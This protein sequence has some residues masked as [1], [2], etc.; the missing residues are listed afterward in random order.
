MQLMRQHVGNPTAGT[1]FVVLRSILGQFLRFTADISDILNPASYGIWRNTALTNTYHY[2]ILLGGTSSYRCRTLL[3]YSVAW[4]TFAN[5]SMFDPEV[6][7]HAAGICGHLVLWP[8]DFLCDEN[9]A[10]SLATRAII[11]TDLWV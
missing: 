7:E 8:M 9:L 4:R 11:P 6:Q 5:G 3:Q 1:E 2:D 10:P